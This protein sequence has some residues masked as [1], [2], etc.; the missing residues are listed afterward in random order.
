VNHPPM[1]NLYRQLVPF[2]DFARNT[3]WVEDK[4]VDYITPGMKAVRKFTNGTP[5]ATQA[6]L[7]QDEGHYLLPSRILKPI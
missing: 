3:L 7:K 4:S 2:K 1:S 6:E 5:T